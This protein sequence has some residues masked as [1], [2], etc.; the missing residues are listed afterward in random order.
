MAPPVEQVTGIQPLDDNVSNKAIES[1]AG[2]V[3]R[4]MN[5]GLRPLYEHLS[6]DTYMH[7]AFIMLASYAFGQCGE[8]YDDLQDNLIAI[9]TRGRQV[10]V[11]ALAQASDSPLVASTYLVKA[12]RDIDNGH[13]FMN[14]CRGFDCIEAEYHIESSMAIHMLI[15]WDESVRQNL[16]HY[17]DLLFADAIAT[18]KKICEEGGKSLAP[19]PI[20][21]ASSAQAPL[22]E[23]SHALG[24]SV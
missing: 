14:N 2:R 6:M 13:R 9:W 1:E 19:Y 3:H 8:I 22:E 5:S 7:E 17:F 20:A 12:G 11:K 15:A 24:P 21:G 10:L 4:A 23:G 16:T 18:W